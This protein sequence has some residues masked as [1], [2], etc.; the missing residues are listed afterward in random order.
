V[1]T[2]SGEPFRALLLTAA[3]SEIGILI[4]SLDYIAP[5]ITM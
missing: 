4:A 2:K 1:T 5:I 3:I